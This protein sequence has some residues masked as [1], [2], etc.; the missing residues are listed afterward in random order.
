MPLT[1][2]E[3]FYA[4]P[5]VIKSILEWPT[6][7][8]TACTQAYCFQDIGSS[9]KATVDKHFHVVEYFWTL[10][11]QFEKD[12]NRCR[13]SVQGTTTVIAQQDTLTAHVHRNPR[14]CC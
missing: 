4:W 12:K 13:R 10:L 3:V 2:D 9:S 6:K 14:I 11:V 5:P 1:V 8:N 7:T